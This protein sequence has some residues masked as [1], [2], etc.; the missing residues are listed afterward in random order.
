MYTSVIADRLK[1][2]VDGVDGSQF[3]VWLSRRWSR[4]VAVSGTVS[5]QDRPTSM[6]WRPRR[7]TYR[8]NLEAIAPDPRSVWVASSLGRRDKPHV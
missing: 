2:E 3:R 8:S 4:I 6:A 1:L 5:Q 7:D